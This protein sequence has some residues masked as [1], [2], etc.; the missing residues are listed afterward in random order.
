[1]VAKSNNGTKPYPMTKEFIKPHLIDLRRL[2]APA[3]EPSDYGFHSKDKY[4]I[5]S[6]SSILISGPPGAGKTNFALSLVRSLYHT[7][8][9]DT[10]KGEDRKQERSFPCLKTMD[11]TQ[12]K[13]IP[14]L[15]YVSLEVFPERLKQALEAFGWFQPDDPLFCVKDRDDWRR[16]VRLVTVPPEIDRPVPGAEELLSNIFSQLADAQ[17]QDDEQRPAVVI[18]DSLTALLRARGDHGERRRQTHETLYRLRKLFPDKLILTILISEQDAGHGRDSSTLAEEF[19]TDIVFRLD[20]DHLLLGR[21]LRKLDVPKSQGVNLMTGEHTWVIVSDRTDQILLASDGFRERIKKSVRYPRLLPQKVLTDAKDRKRLLQNVTGMIEWLENKA[22]WKLTFDAIEEKHKADGT[23]NGGTDEDIAKAAKERADEERTAWVALEKKWKKA[24]ENLRESLKAVIHAGASISGPYFGNDHVRLEEDFVKLLRRWRDNL[25]NV[26]AVANVEKAYSALVTSRNAL[27]GYQQFLEKCQSEALY[28]SAVLLPR[29]PGFLRPE[30]SEKPESSPSRSAGPYICSGTAGL[31]AM[32]RYRPEDWLSGAPQPFNGLRDETNTLLIGPPGSGK[33]TIAYQFL[34]GLYHEKNPPRKDNQHFPP[35]LVSFDSN[36]KQAQSALDAAWEKYR[37]GAQLEKPARSKHGTSL[38]SLR[39]G[40]VDLNLVIAQIRELIMGRDWDGPSRLVIDG[41]SEWLSSQE[42]ERESNK[43]LILEALLN[44]I[45][46]ARIERASHREKEGKPRI[47]LTV[48]IC[49]E[50]ETDD[51]AALSE[52]FGIPADNIVVIRQVQMRR[53][54]YVVKA[55]G[56]HHDRAVRE[57]RA[58]VEDGPLQFVAGVDR[59]KG[60][61]EG[62]QEPATVVLQCFQENRAES[63]WM[64]WAV[65]ELKSLI[66]V[67]YSVLSFGRSDNSRTFERQGRAVSGASPELRIMTVDEWWLTKNSVPPLSHGEEKT[68]NS[69]GTAIPLVELSGLWTSSEDSEQAAHQGLDASWSDYWHFEVQKAM[70]TTDSKSPSVACLAVPAH[71]DFGM[72]C[73]NLRAIEEYPN[74]KLAEHLSKSR[75][76]S[77]KWAELL[78]RLPRTWVP[79]RW[80]P[81]QLS[82]RRPSKQDMLSIAAATL[83]NDFLSGFPSFVNRESGKQ[84]APYWFAFDT[85]TPETLVS[86]WL[87][88]A[89]TFGATADFLSA[90]SIGAVKTWPETRALV[91]LQELI[92]RGLMPARATIEDT[93]KSIFSRQWWSTLKYLNAGPASGGDEEDGHDAVEAGANMLPLPFL[94]AES[95]SPREWCKFFAQTAARLQETLERLKTAFDERTREVCPVRFREMAQIRSLGPQITSSVAALEEGLRLVAFDATK[96]KAKVSELAGYIVKAEGA[97]LNLLDST[98]DS[99]QLFQTPPLEE[100]HRKDTPPVEPR[101]QSAL[102]ADYRDLVE[103]F[104]SHN[105]R[106]QMLK[107]SLEGNDLLEAINE[108]RKAPNK[109]AALPNSMDLRKASASALSGLGTSGSWYYAIHRSSQS[110]SLA[111]AILAELTSLKASEERAKLGAGLP[112][113]KD[114]YTTSGN[115]P[116][117][118]CEH[119]TWRELLRFA[120]SRCRSRRRVTESKDFANST[121]ILALF[122]LIACR[123]QD[124]F[125]QAEDDRP[126]SDKELTKPLENALKRAVLLVDEIHRASQ[127]YTRNKR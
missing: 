69:K 36:L 111:P 120:G 68:S 39:Q 38:L 99:P 98:K 28:G 125:Q 113:R 90:A 24:L 17:A 18:I 114:F 84:S 83:P 55:A 11:D 126:T 100:L 30:H 118:G 26:S 102:C 64:K 116:V 1:M 70:F 60:L 48:F 13:K 47:P 117:P 104:Q 105:L 119:L 50:V 108:W 93:G 103:H 80:K 45:A 58:V 121:D 4:A 81:G 51:T 89:W 12:W 62:K 52:T 25:S 41:L 57:V 22:N 19:L 37:H 106:M 123:L 15:Y 109:C 20:L 92:L 29:S 23:A 65:S 74:S 85:S 78:A 87:E 21:R 77:E 124:C 46:S 122:H 34:F 107:A 8:L 44:S 101:T 56:E 53:L 94:P 43:A 91:F 115:H 6:G 54:A 3:L 127:Q 73:V 32:L 35:A 110:L 42:D 5:P 96:A 16:T 7:A 79:E 49:Y 31:D 2:F 33:S 75:S 27:K 14:I 67:N 9:I 76:Q 82:K 95:N 72:F 40:H 86:V 59:Y 61:L 63:D 88:M 10:H 71:M 97:I 66:P 112:A